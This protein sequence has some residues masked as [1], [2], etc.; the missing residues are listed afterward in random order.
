[1]DKGVG[2][3]DSRSNMKEYSGNEEIEKEAMKKNR[4]L[5]TNTSGKEKN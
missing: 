4:P 5:A 1:M 3:N 2:E